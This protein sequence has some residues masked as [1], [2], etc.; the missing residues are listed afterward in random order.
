M[1]IEIFSMGSP[2]DRKT[3]RHALIWMW[4]ISSQL[5]QLLQPLR[6]SPL[7]L[8]PHLIQR[9]IR[10][11]CVVFGVKLKDAL[12][13]QSAATLM[14]NL[15]FTE[16]NNNNSNSSKSS[17][18][19][20]AITRTKIQIDSSPL[21]QTIKFLNDSSPLAVIYQKVAQLC[22]GY[23]LLIQQLPL[24]RNRIWW[25]RML[26]LLSWWQASLNLHLQASQKLPI[27]HRRSH[28]NLVAPSKYLHLIKTHIVRTSNLRAKSIL[29]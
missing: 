13:A 19:S 15:N 14:A 9:S 3:K 17:W 18:S 16:S 25:E 28:S 26:L 27:S 29:S 7:T 21:L 23:S 2:K 12:S 8:Y 5:L 4:K 10:L 6:W 22:K 24:P 20:S 1:K 11:S